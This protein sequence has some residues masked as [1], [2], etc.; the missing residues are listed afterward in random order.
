VGVEEG[1]IGLDMMI[2]MSVRCW[3]VG[4]ILMDRL[5]IGE[6]RGYRDWVDRAVVVVVVVW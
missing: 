6:A 5:W 2:W 3:I 4:E 1:S